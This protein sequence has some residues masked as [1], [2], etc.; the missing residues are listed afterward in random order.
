MYLNLKMR[1]KTDNVIFRYSRHKTA[2][3]LQIAAKS[4]LGH[5]TCILDDQLCLPRASPTYFSS[6]DIYEDLFV[7][8]IV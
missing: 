3:T 7:G 5:V 2:C 4:I 1:E 8:L 6:Q